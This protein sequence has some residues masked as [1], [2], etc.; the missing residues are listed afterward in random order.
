L[1]FLPFVTRKAV[2]CD[3]LHNIRGF[4]AIKI[5]SAFFLKSVIRGVVHPFLIITQ[6]LWRKGDDKIKKVEGSALNRME[7][8]ETHRGRWIR[9]DRKGSVKLFDGLLISCHVMSLFCF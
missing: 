8:L 9:G 1:R 7:E 3:F 6:H 5:S 2:F 4:D